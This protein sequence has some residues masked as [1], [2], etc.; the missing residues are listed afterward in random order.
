MAFVSSGGEGGCVDRCTKP[1]AYPNAG[2]GRMQIA[3]L[4]RLIDQKSCCTLIGVQNAHCK[5]AYSSHNDM[6]R[7]LGFTSK[8][9]APQPSDARPLRLDSVA[10]VL[11]GSSTLIWNILATLRTK[12]PAYFFAG[13][14]AYQQL[15]D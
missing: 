15:S 10:E 14:G 3:F 12:I 6:Y 9:P 8:G 7:R 1:T 13:P 4:F 2:Y 11:A 5:V